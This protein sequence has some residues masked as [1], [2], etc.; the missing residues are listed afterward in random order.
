MIDY[1][2]HTNIS[3]DCT[4]P[5][6]LMAKAARDAGIKEVGFAEHIDFD[7]PCEFDFSKIDFEAYNAAYEETK[8]EFPDLALRRG[9]EAGLDPAT[10][11]RMRA[12]LAGFPCDFVIGSQHIVFGNDPYYDPVW[13]G[14][15]QRELYDE[16]IRMSLETVENCEFFDVLGHLGYIAKFCPYEDKLMRYTDYPDA[17]ET[18]LKTLVQRGKGLEANTNGLYMTPSTM[19]ETEIIKRYREL[20]GEIITIG[21]DAHYESVVGHA[22]KETLETLKDIGFKYVCAFDN[23][24]PRFIAIP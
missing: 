5:M 6:R 10:M 15:T 2:I 17:I 8:R 13:Q 3:A 7:L 24:Q 1:H 9:I 21:S 4:V 23:R 11:D 22:V 18:I 19:P 14:H 12:L 16:Y 20:G